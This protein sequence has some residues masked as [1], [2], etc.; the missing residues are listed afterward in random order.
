MGHDDGNQVRVFKSIEMFLI[1][2]PMIKFKVQM[3]EPQNV[4][5]RLNPQDNEAQH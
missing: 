4:N 2:T 1:F 3:L 5:E